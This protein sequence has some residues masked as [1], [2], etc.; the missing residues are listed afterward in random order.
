MRG[1]GWSDLRMLG[2]VVPFAAIPTSTI[3]S[4]NG[5]NGRLLSWLR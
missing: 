5:W 3:V 2:E 4:G 1:F